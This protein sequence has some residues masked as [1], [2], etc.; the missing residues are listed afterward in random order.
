MKIINVTTKR[1][2]ER[3]Y[4]GLNVTQL[5]VYVLGLYFEWWHSHDHGQH[6]RRLC[7]FSAFSFHLWTGRLN[8][9]NGRGFEIAIS[10]LRYGMWFN[11]IA[12]W[13]VGVSDRSY[14][15]NNRRPIHRLGRLAFCNHNAEYKRDDQDQIDEYHEEMS[16]YFNEVE[17]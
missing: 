14:G 2:N 6:H 17:E 5:A 8:Y 9:L 13:S 7:V 12:N 1:I 10:T 3:H 4:T 11:R 16:Q 15:I